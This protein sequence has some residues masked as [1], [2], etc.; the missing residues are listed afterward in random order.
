VLVVALIVFFGVLWLR[1]R[2]PLIGIAALTGLC[3]LIF[4]LGVSYIDRDAHHFGKFY[5]FRPSSLT[6]LFTLATLL[7]VFEPFARGQ[8][9]LAWNALA[10]I[11]VVGVVLLSAKQQIYSFHNI[12]GLHANDAMVAA[13]HKLSGPDDIV[14]LEP[15]GEMDDNFNRLPRLIERPT[16]VSWKFVPTNPQQILRWYSLVKTRETL[17]KEG[18]KSA[19]PFTPTLLVSFTET[20]GAALANCGPVIW[21]EGATRVVKYQPGAASETGVTPE[22][23]TASQTDA[24]PQS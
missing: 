18:C 17:F 15:F 20:A 2:L 11:A 9:K 6:L 7:L 8:L 23:S 10:A 22:T 3:F 16:V 13:V 12:A 19:L 14:L 24:G 21:Q 5:L 4:A 1:G